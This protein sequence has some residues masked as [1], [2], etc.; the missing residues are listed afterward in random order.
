MH[1]LQLPSQA[2]GIRDKHS[3]AMGPPDGR[4]A[5]VSYSVEFVLCYA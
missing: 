5:A 1:L 4:V 3:A 2:L